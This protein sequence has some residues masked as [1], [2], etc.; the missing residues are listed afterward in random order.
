MGDA[1]HVVE[2][3]EPSRGAG[4]RTA[5]D[6]VASSSAVS[7]ERK[8]R[9]IHRRRS[10]RARLSRPEISTLEMKRMGHSL[11][12]YGSE[13][14]SQKLVPPEGMAGVSGGGLSLDELVSQMVDPGASM[15]K[16]QWIID[17][18]SP[19]MRNW[20]VVM[21]VLLMFTATVTPY[22]TAL[23]P[24]RWDA[25]FWINR[26][27]DVCFLVDIC[28]N[29][30]TA[31]PGEDEHWVSSHRRIALHYCRTW[32][33]I[34]VL[35]ILP[36]ETAGFL[37]QNDSLDGLKIL[38]VVRLL[39][40]LKLFRVLRAG[41]IFQ[42]WETSL[43]MNFSLLSLIKFIL[44]LSIMAHWFACGWLIVAQL[45]MDGNPEAETWITQAGLRDGSV[46]DLY[47]AAVYWAVMT[48]STIG[49]G[50]IYA[51]STNERYFCTAAMLIGA[52]QWA[53]IVG[54][55]CGIMASLDAQTLVFRQ[56][57]DELN[58]Y[59]KEQKISE[60]L[61]RRLREYFHQ[62]KTL[63]RVLNSKDLLKKMSPALRGEVALTT[64]KTWV[65]RVSYFASMDSRNQAFITLIALSLHPAVYA[66]KEL[67]AGDELHIVMRGVVIKDGRILATGNVWGED[68]VLRT[69]ALANTKTARA[70]TYVDVFLLA[71][72]ELMDILERFPLERAHIR[73]ATVRMAF[74]RALIRHAKVVAVARDREAMIARAASASASEGSAKPL[75]DTIVEPEPTPSDTSGVSPGPPT[76]LAAA[77]AAGGSM[78]RMSS[79]HPSMRVSSMRATSM[80]VSGSKKEEELARGRSA[81]SLLDSLVDDDA[82]RAEIVADAS[83]HGKTSRS[84]MMRLVDK[85]RRRDEAAA[86]PR[87]TPPPVGDGGA[88]SSPSSTPLSPVSSEQHAAMQ[89]QLHAMD[90]KI[91]QLAHMLESR[92]GSIISMLPQTADSA[93]GRAP[94]PALR[95]LAPM[96]FA[97][98]PD[99]LSSDSARAPG[100]PG[101]ALSPVA[102][103]TVA[104][105]AATTA[106]GSAASAE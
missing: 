38:R 83:S 93:A 98:S 76:T 75:L 31:Y 50:D 59:M 102:A 97:S 81:F 87:G 10:S 96:R 45:E 86:L 94:L 29:F 100:S 54:N 104:A 32:F 26:L 41:R 6:E 63:V 57:L 14:S 53:Y 89:Q 69:R 99:L 61:Q 19:A 12:V 91:E 2:D 80:R 51:Q 13:L 55:V 23:L 18:R 1:Y 103:A 24:T 34:D 15:E 25:L 40:L 58:Y 78:P 73:R 72:A 56:T 22:E 82:H 84:K 21:L 16:K 27:V 9:D 49:Y 74:R 62:R 60:D 36:F 11:G 39:R 105:A 47:A 7:D 20:D 44:V 33:V 65:E 106:A 48:L 101:G 52:G 88:P 70:L 67:I 90:A 85:V 28:L 5:R 4:G 64:N 43:N 8:A 30:F 77:A 79:L 46:S 3:D 35:S 68:M 37:L 92:I 17:P 66:P 71:Y 42:R 95:P